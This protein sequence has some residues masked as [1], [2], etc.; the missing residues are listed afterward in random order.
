MSGYSEDKYT[1]EKIPCPV[2]GKEAIMRS[3]VRNIPYYGELRIISIRCPHCG[4][5]FSD[6]YLLR[7]EKPKKVRLKIESPKDLEAMLVLTS[8]ATIRIP[9]LGIEVTPG[10]IAKGRMLPVSAFLMEAADMTRLAMKEPEGE[11]EEER[12]KSIERGK[13]IIKTI[14]E[15]LAKPSGKLTIEIEDPTGGSDIIPEEIRSKRAEEERKRSFS[16]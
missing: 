2:C 6:V 5:R 4:Y 14:E 11:T 9:E 10:P 7:D 15:E 13:K 8:R 12:K 3:I 1:E 16:S